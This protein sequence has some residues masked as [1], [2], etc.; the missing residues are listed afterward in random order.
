LKKWLVAGYEPKSRVCGVGNVKL[1]SAEAV[2]FSTPSAK[3]ADNLRPH[4]LKDLRVRLTRFAQEFGEGKLADIAPAARHVNRTLAA[5]KIKQLL[6]ARRAGNG[7]GAPGSPESATSGMHL[8][9]IVL[10]TGSEPTAA[11]WAQ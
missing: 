6:K 3:R 8:A 11:F 9:P 4:Y 10:A 2:I 5:A 7:N 1:Q